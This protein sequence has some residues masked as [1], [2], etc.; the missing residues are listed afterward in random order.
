MD[1]IHIVHSQ[2]LMIIESDIEL[3]TRLCG[4]HGSASMYLDI[5]SDLSFSSR[6]YW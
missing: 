3:H 5:A 6:R 4:T 1:S 2:Q